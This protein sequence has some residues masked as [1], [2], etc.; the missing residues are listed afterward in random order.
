MLRIDWLWLK[1]HKYCTR[2]ASLLLTWFFAIWRPTCLNARLLPLQSN[3]TQLKWFMRKQ[4]WF[5]ACFLKMST[6]TITAFIW[7]SGSSS[8]SKS[9]VIKFLKKCE[10]FLLFEWCN[11]FSTVIRKKISISFSF[12][13]DTIHV[14][15]FFF[16][17]LNKG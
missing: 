10:S 15:S 1:R 14:W 5:K 12:F 7:A 9:K 4:K 6:K 11:S 2:Q 17:Y 13:V 3:L 8:S 16:G